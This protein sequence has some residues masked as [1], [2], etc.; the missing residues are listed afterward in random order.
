MSAHDSE[1]P[2]ARMTFVNVDKSGVSMSWKT[3]AAVLTV[4][5]VSMGGGLGYLATL[6]TKEDV[7]RHNADN[8][9]HLITVQN[10]YTSKAEAQ[11]LPE[12]V[13][14]MHMKVQKIDD[15]EDKV[16]KVQTTVVEDQAERLADRAADKAP[17]RKLETWRKVKAKA[18]RNKRDGKPMRDGLEDLVF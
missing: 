10:P 3:T 7:K 6:A 17:Q 2:A 11:P 15:I 12:V 1:R 14:D 18:M 8:H 5:V 16:E 4:I 13:S 9:A